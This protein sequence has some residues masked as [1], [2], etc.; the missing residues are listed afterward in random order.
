MTSH[1]A[2][3]QESSPPSAVVEKVT[4]DLERDLGYFRNETPA[5][6]AAFQLAEFTLRGVRSAFVCVTCSRHDSCSSIGL[7]LREVQVALVSEKPN[8]SP[9]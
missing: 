9:Q 7:D 3:L 2:H 5:G 1:P 6:G 4:G 8:R